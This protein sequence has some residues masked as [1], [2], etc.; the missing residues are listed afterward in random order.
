MIPS[1][2]WRPSSSPPTASSS[3][4]MR[5]SD[6]LETTTSFTATVPPVGVLELERRQLDDVVLAGEDAAEALLEVAPAHRA[7][8]ADASEVD[9]DHG[10]A[11]AEEARERPQHRAVAA[12]DDREVGGTCL[13]GRV[14]AVLLRLLGREDELDAVLLGDGLEP[15]EARADLPRLA[16]GDDGGAGDAATRRHR[17]SSALTHRGSIR[18]VRVGD[19]RRT[20]GSPSGRAAP[21]LRRRP[22]RHPTPARLR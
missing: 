20:P 21:S 10:N 18:R 12:E 1:H 8:E 4:I 17:R 7:Q 9:A 14:D 2:G 11:G 13:V 22:S 15:C 16:V 5:P 19:G 6:A 3:S